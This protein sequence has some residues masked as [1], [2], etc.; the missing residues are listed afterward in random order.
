VTPKTPAQKGEENKGK[1]GE[2]GG[3]NPKALPKEIRFPPPQ[4]SKGPKG[5]TPIRPL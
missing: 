5:R 3:V 1:K 4:K 2:K